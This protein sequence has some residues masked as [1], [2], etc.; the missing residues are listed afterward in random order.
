MNP[1]NL[2]SVNAGTN[3]ALVVQN[4][5]DAQATL[6]LYDLAGNLLLILEIDPGRSEIQTTL[7]GVQLISVKGSGNLQVFRIFLN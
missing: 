3:G 6:N 5:S 4:A 7:Q 2:F 1:G